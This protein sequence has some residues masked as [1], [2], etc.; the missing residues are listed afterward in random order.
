MLTGTLAL[1]NRRWFSSLFSY[2]T[3][4]F[5]VY[6]KR[7]YHSSL[8]AIIFYP[9]FYYLI[10]FNSLATQ[11]FIIVW[12]VAVFCCNNSIFYIQNIKIYNTPQIYCLHD[13]VRLYTRHLC[14]DHILV[15]LYFLMWLTRRVP[16]KW[17]S[18]H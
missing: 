4:E 8:N 11:F 16:W 7:S 13:R 6:M 15:L 14:C 10:Y 18:F 17:L 2:Q 12:F 3:D 1:T 5:P 9:I